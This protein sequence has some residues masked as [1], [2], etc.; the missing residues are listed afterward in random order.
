MFFDRAFLESEI[1]FDKD[2][3]LERETVFER[4]ACLESEMFFERAACFES[5]IF[6]DRA[7]LDTVTR[8]LATGLSET[9]SHKLLPLTKAIRMPKLEISENCR[10]GRYLAFLSPAEGDSIRSWFWIGE[11][12]TL[13]GLI[14][15]PLG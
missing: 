11:K 10:K 13:M 1:F 14:I 12:L 4:D 2:I 3:C 6:F 9:E 15:N 7:F 5:E 8:R